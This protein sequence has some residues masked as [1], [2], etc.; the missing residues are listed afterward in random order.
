MRTPRHLECAQVQKRSTPS[1][2]YFNTTSQHHK[3]HNRDAGLSSVE[4]H[5]CGGCV[6]VLFM[7]LS[8]WLVVVAIVVKSFAETGEHE[9]PLNSFTLRPSPRST[10]C[11][12][13]HARPHSRSELTKLFHDIVF[14][15]SLFVRALLLPMASNSL[16]SCSALTTMIVMHRIARPEVQYRTDVSHVVSRNGT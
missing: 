8:W 15:M 4:S 13:H 2:A 9:H 11:M 10:Y 16:L 1:C 7:F 3:P 5:F 14:R 6:N 12:T